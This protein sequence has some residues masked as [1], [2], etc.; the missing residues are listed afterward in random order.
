MKQT[1]LIL[2]II[3]LIASITFGVLSIVNL[4]KKKAENTDS[5]SITIQKG[6]IVYFNMDRV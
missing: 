2:S 5:T 4:D 3:A 1:S 6:A